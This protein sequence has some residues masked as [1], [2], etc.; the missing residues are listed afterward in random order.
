MVSPAS[1]P[2][3]AT[4]WWCRSL[5]FASAGRKLR[6]QLG[7]VCGSK[8]T[9]T[10]VT[11]VTTPLPPQLQSRTVSAGSVW[12]WLWAL[13][14]FFP[15]RLGILE[16]WEWLTLHPVTAPPR[17][18]SLTW[19]VLWI[20]RTVLRHFQAVISGCEIN[21]R[22]CPCF[23]RCRKKNGKMKGPCFE[24]GRMKISTLNFKGESWWRNIK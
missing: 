24:K 8:H 3:V 9:E 14:C 7:A 18:L 21:L 10:P 13:V 15:C 16:E 4:Y 1:R 2:A 19:W 23:C 22:S 17:E 20:G 6:W 12:P 11:C 5:L